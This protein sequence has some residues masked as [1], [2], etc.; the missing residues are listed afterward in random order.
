MAWNLKESGYKRSP[1]SSF[2]FA[3]DISETMYEEQE[4]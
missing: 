4:V 1:V 3:A 2:F